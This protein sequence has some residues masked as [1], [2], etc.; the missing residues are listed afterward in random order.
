[1]PER[2]AAYLR[3][4]SIAQAEDDRW[5]YERQ[6]REVLAYAE[7]HDLQIDHTYRDAIT[8]TSTT[9][10]GLDQ[11]LAHAHQ[12]D[13][14]I[15]S[16]VD[17][18]GREV[19]AT[20]QV[21]QDLKRAGL[22][23]HVTNAGEIKTEDDAGLIHFV[24]SSLFADLERRAISSRTQA[25]LVMMAE[26]GKLP[27]G[28]RTYGYNHDDK[29][30]AIIRPDQAR[31]VRRIYRERIEGRSFRSIALALEADRIPVARPHRAPDGRGRWGYGTIGKLIRNR[32]YKGEYLWS[33]NG[34][35]WLIPIPP[36]VDEATWVAAQPRKRGPAPRKDW[37]LLGH[38]RCGRCGRRMHAR[39]SIKRGKPY[40]YYRCQALDRPEIRHTCDQ[41]LVRRD[42]LE[43][44]AE[45]AVRERLT[46]PTE[47]RALLAAA[48]EQR[49]DPNA[50][51]RAALREERAR[52]LLAYRHGVLDLDEFT[53][54]RGEIDA[55]LTALTQA[56]AGEDAPVELLARA[57][58]T[59][60][61][62]ELL[63]EGGIVVV[64]DPP[65]VRFTIE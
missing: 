50:D 12:L 40:D 22:A 19:A 6:H 58:A 38:V 60:P 56:P 31:I 3:V 21:F 39:T 13:V 16:S 26:A 29:G 15:I 46:D 51:R 44:A 2:A 59:V 20:Q 23:V 49:G 7:H 5:G 41:K 61:L 63:E 36:I 64:V 1:M 52:L 42:W 43:Q 45:T 47:L 8:G 32:A 18:L 27:N 65:N 57:A 4:S 28:I 33:R 48:E 35:K 14:V 17:R 25:A 24:L 53:T 55:D 10:V 11:L 54:A 34:R 62:R 37:P 9:R 30:G